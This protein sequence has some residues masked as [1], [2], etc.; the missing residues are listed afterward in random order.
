MSKAFRIAVAASF[1]SIVAVAWA[2]Q[3]AAP[4]AFRDVPWFMRLGQRVAKV[5]D[6][7]PFE[8]RVVLVPDEATFLDEI[9]KWRAGRSVLDTAP[10][11]RDRV[12]GCWPVLIEDEVFTPLFLRAYKPAKVIRRTEKAPPLADA[13]A[14]RTAVRKAIFDCWFSPPDATGDDRARFAREDHTPA[15]LV[16]YSP[17]DP[18]FVAAAA[19]GAADGLIPVEI[20]G[21]FGK[22]NDTIDQARFTPLAEGIR[23]AFAGTGMEYRRLGDELD[24]IAL[25]LGTAQRVVLDLPVD[26]RPAAPGM[27]AVNPA[28]PVAMTDAL[29]RNDDGSRFGVCGGIFGSAPRA[30]YMAMCS[31]FLPRT[32]LWCV[33]SYA[34]GPQFSSYGFAPV[35]PILTQAGVAHRV[36][37]GRA[38]DIGSWRTWL[39]TGFECDMLFVNSS[40]NGDFFDL[41]VPGGTGGKSRG[42]PGDIPVLDRP[43]ALNM[44]HSWSLVAPDERETVGGRWLESGVYGYVGSVHEPF[45][46]AFMPP[47]LQLERLVN[48]TPF[49]VA[50]RH[51]DGPFSR[52]WR[53]DTLGD[54]LMIC[55]V[56]EGWKLPPRVAPTPIVPGQEDAVAACGRLLAACK[57][58]GDGQASMLAMQELARLGKDEIAVQLWKLCSDKPWS[59]R[60][61]PFALGPL[62]NQREQEAFLNAYG[63]TPTPTARQRDMLWQL[64]GPQVGQLSDPAQ[65]ELFAGAVRKSWP[66]MDWERLK[67]PMGA[68]LGTQVVRSAMLRTAQGTQNEQHRKA[69]EEL[70]KN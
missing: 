10:A 4:A 47:S 15:G 58:D 34:E 59:V 17:K 43:L 9:S 29:C 67:G 56:P 64:W 1:A 42:G 16:A 11:N 50:G 27:P 30:A 52:T 45:L 28:D 65:L 40:G 18:A 51:F 48:L 38:A 63:R 69:M 36:F 6:R 31:V 44:I 12:Q 55:G 53:I 62:F 19:L 61:A 37:Q 25:C 13:A 66:S 20:E 2:R 49:L 32:T 14:V 21:D 3:D 54:P 46:P 68:A 57:G 60:V 7:V 8:D 22:P 39:M 24:T 5:R 33:D 26:Q 23:A 35:A 70:L 41:G